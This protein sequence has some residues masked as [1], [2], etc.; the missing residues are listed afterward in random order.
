[1]HATFN[2]LTTLTLEEFRAG[3]P[4]I[5]NFFPPEPRTG[6][7]LGEYL[8][9]TVGREFLFVKA[10]GPAFIWTLIDNNEGDLFLSSGLHWANRLGYLISKNPVLPRVQFEVPLS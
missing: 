6:T 4:L 9:E 2:T 3:F 8:F 7:L 1:M 10:Q 5:E